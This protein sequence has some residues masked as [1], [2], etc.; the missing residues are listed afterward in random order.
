MEL[1]VQRGR[2]CPSWRARP[3]KEAAVGGADPLPAAGKPKCVPWRY[4]DSFSGK[5]LYALKCHPDQHVDFSGNLLLKVSCKW[6][7]NPHDHVDANGFGYLTGHGAET[8][9]RPPWVTVL[10]QEITSC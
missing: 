4:F 10:V 9:R 2:M 5:N 7:L 8:V 6:H 1:L 3:W